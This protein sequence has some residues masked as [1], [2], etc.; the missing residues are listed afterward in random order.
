[1]LLYKKAANLNLTKEDKYIINL[2]KND[3][4]KKLKLLQYEK[5]IL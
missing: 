4:H 3:E 2:S 1:M 5:R